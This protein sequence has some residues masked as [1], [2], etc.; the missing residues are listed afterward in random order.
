MSKS[1]DSAIKL[2]F[3]GDFKNVMRA[4]VKKVFGGWE[5]FVLDDQESFRWGVTMRK[6]VAGAVLRNRRRRQGKEV[7]RKV[8]GIW[9][10][11]LGLDKGPK[12]L[13]VLL[14]WHG[15]DSDKVAYVDLCR[16][17]EFLCLRAKN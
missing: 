17:S 11:R 9:E 15:F 2:R 7:V 8:F 6:G 10:K 1:F 14:R 4:G 3:S 16:A 12:G 5:T 13:V